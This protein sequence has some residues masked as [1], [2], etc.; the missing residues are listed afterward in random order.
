MT[1]SQTIEVVPCSL[2]GSSCA[3]AI[4]RNASSA[5]RSDKSRETIMKIRKRKQAMKKG[6]EKRHAQSR[7]LGTPRKKRRT[8]N[9]WTG[10]T[11]AENAMTNC[12]SSGP[13]G[14]LKIW[15]WDENTWAKVSSRK[16]LQTYK[17]RMWA[18]R[19]PSKL[20]QRRAQVKI[21]R[22]LYSWIWTSF[23]VQNARQIRR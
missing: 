12:Q 2:A 8:E 14:C 11:H 13:N 4:A 19:C 18:S 21:W 22:D 23:V 3:S 1:N 7:L 6:E 9:P 5:R 10:I 17:N 16:T 20:R 15:A